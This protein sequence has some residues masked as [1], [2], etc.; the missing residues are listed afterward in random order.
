MNEAKRK[1]PKNRS[2]KQKSALYNIDTLYKSRE[3]I[4]KFFDHY[5]SMA[6]EAK[7]EVIKGT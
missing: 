7:H 5:S 3:A 6:S 4:I 1:Q 2:D